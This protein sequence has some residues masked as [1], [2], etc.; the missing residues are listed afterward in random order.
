MSRRLAWLLA[1]RSLPASGF[2][3]WCAAG[4]WASGLVGAAA[5]A[6][7]LFGSFGLPLA[8]VAWLTLL[9]LVAP[10][11]GTALDA[12]L[13]RNGWEGLSF[14]SLA[15]AV[16]LLVAL[17][18][19][20]EFTFGAGLVAVL[21]ALTGAG[22]AQ[23]RAHAGSGLVLACAGL[24]VVLAFRQ[25]F[26]DPLVVAAFLAVSATTGA[27][28]HGRATRRR[29]RLA[30]GAGVSPVPGL[31]GMLTR[32]LPGL[33]LGLALVAAEWTGLLPEA[34]AAAAA[35]DGSAA[36]SGGDALEPAEPRG[37]ARL[38]GRDA[39]RQEL[40]SASPARAFRSEVRPSAR[41]ARM[42]DSVVLE[43]EP[44]PPPPSGELPAGSLYLRALAYRE[45]RPDATMAAE[46]APPASKRDADDGRLDGWIHF[47]ADSPAA[48]PREY[49]LRQNPFQLFDEARPGRSLCFVIED[50]VAVAAPVLW[51]ERGGYWMEAEAGGLLDYRLRA[52]PVP[53]AALGR[54]LGPLEGPQEGFVELPPGGESLQRIRDLGRRLWKPEDDAWRRLEAIQ[55]F[56]ADGFQ[57]FLDGCGPGFDG[58]A[59][60]LES[61]RGYCSAF[62]M[63]GVILLRDA[64]IPCRMAV[65]YLADRRK[66]DPARRLYV[67]RTGDAH[68]WIEVPVR[69]RG[70]LPLEL[71]PPT[72]L[73]VVES[74][75]AAAG[76]APVSEA[77]PLAPE[78][79]DG[80]GEEAP[81]ADSKPPDQGAGADWRWLGLA[82]S[83]LAL[84]ALLRRR[85][86]QT[87][88]PAGEPPRPRAGLDT[89]I[90]ALLAA[91]AA[92][93]YRIR[94]AQTPLEFARELARAGPPALPQVLEILPELYR[95][96]YRGDPLATAAEARLRALVAE[97]ASSRA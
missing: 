4:L 86:S 40:G 88:D 10:T 13:R 77:E 84:A 22:L 27:W 17:F 32:A 55:E 89:A 28:L 24:L 48:R 9:L 81:G 1:R 73:A 95:A 41:A 94:P 93:G 34:P 20:G 14:R 62:A 39:R 25:G 23:P 90:G 33:L 30:R 44:L 67:I 36:S 72:R 2:D 16:S 85:S 65:G 56:Y 43:V 66:W 92:A 57:Y 15:M 38:G 49:R 47:L 78:P 8:S 31:P 54:R 19:L 96:R 75:A 6:A 53:A 79:G 60:F 91:L 97:L 12:L 50:A 42:S 69:G 5:A 46:A 29:A 76:L 63:T 87:P 35:A 74:A 58:L 26:L 3:P 18:G 51:R 71:T 83:A 11:G 21:L 37:G 80:G 61:K 45:L 68:A 59:A 52:L 64:G 82:A 70:W 7:L